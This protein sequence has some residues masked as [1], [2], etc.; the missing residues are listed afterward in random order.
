MGH[1]CSGRCFHERARVTKVV[2]RQQ[3]V[4]GLKILSDSDP[5]KRVLDATRLDL[6]AKN[7]GS[8]DVPRAS[9]IA[10]CK[11]HI[12]VSEPVLL[13][14]V[15]WKVHALDISQIEAEVGDIGNRQV[16]FRV[17]AGFILALLL[18]AK[19][20]LADIV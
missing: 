14:S 1:S 9:D 4:L 2:E 5:H 18:E 20:Q 8:S 12:S 6:V 19:L 15:A 10:F 17:S 3:D 7:G 13:K 11:E 16:W